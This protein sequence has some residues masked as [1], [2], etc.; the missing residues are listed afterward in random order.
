MKNII[1]ILLLS[2]LFSSC[3]KDNR[4]RYEQR[5]NIQVDIPS[6]LNLIET[7]AFIINDIPSFYKTSLNINGYQEADVDEILASEGAFNLIFNNGGLNFIEKISIRI[8]EKSN[9]LSYREM[10]YFDFVPLNEDASINL[11]PGIANLQKYIE[12]DNFS[13]EVRLKFRSYVPPGTRLSLDFGYNV[14]INN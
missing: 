9:P 14:F 7:H 8:Y 11:F 3:N 6:G 12:N 5:L 2:F 4:Q 10:Y 1:I 13:L